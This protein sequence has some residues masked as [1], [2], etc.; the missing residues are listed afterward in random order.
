MVKTIF[1]F[2]ITMGKHG[3]SSKVTTNFG[4]WIA[5]IHHHEFIK[6]GVF[7]TDKIAYIIQLRKLN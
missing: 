4:Q 3:Q 5:L 1:V 2:H 6:C 7:L